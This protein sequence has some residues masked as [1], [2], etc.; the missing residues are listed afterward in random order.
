LVLVA[1]GLVSPA[2]QTPIPAI[3]AS[4]RSSRSEALLHVDSCGFD[5]APPLTAATMGRGGGAADTGI[6]EPRP[7]DRARD[8]A[9]EYQPA[10]TEPQYPAG[11]AHVHVVSIYQPAGVENAKGAREGHVDLN[12]STQCLLLVA[13]EPT[14][15]ARNGR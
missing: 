2:V 7:A 11:N 12:V 13:F 10:A 9:R 5:P 15:V 3:G 14:G 6:S 8:D 4:L 1:E